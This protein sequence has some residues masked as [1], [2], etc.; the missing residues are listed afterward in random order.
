MDKETRKKCGAKNRSGNPCG[1]WPSKNRSRCALHGGKSLVGVSSPAYKNGR[2]SNSLP[3]GLREKYEATLNDPNLLTLEAEIRLLDVQLAEWTGLLQDGGENTEAWARVIVAIEA[4]RK[5]LESEMKRV[6]ADSQSMPGEQLLVLIDFLCDTMRQAVFNHT[7][8]ATGR[9]I[10]AE[11]LEGIGRF[12][13]KTDLS[14][15]E[16][17]MLA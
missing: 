4:R 15:A 11:L 6:H 10:L 13:A 8:S 2:Y 17:K 5:L 7:D 9:K 1:K 16:R 3:R 14:P 12:M